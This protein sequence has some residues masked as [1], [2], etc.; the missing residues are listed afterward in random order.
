M[1]SALL[2]ATWQ[3]GLI[4][5]S[6]SSRESALSVGRKIQGCSAHQHMPTCSPRSVLRA[7][8]RLVTSAWWLAAVPRMPAL[9]R[10]TPSRQVF[11]AASVM[12]ASRELLEG[13]PGNFDSA[14]NSSHSCR[15]VSNMSSSASELLFNPAAGSAP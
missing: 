4:L 7:T 11:A 2:A 14:S 1:H 10:V 15:R 12:L 13:V 3:G 6:Q 5:I 9:G 8:V